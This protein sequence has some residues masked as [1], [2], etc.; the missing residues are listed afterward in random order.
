MK[1][2]LTSSTFYPE[3]AGLHPVAY[4]AAKDWMRRGHQVR[5]LTNTPGSF[6]GEDEIQIIRQ[7]RYRD[8]LNQYR[9]CDVVFQN[10][11]SIRYWLPGLLVQRPYVVSMG[12]YS[13]V[14]A[15]NHP[16]NTRLIVHM[17]QWIRTL[18]LRNATRNI[19][20]SAAVATGNRVPSRIIPPQFD[21]TQFKNIIPTSQRSSALLYVGRLVSDKGVDDLIRAVALVRKRGTDCRLVIVGA[22]PSRSSLESLAQEKGITDV[23]SFVGSKTPEEVSKLMNS[24]R[25]IVVPSKY[26]DPAPVIALEAIASGCDVIGTEGGGLA[27]NIGFCGLT[28]PNGDYI[29]L[30]G[31]IASVLAK[32]DQ[33]GEFADTK[34]R[35]LAR[36]HPERIGG[37]FLEE[38][39]NAYRLFHR[40]PDPE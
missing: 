6:P 7:P 28:Y 17:K 2:L 21:S 15:A 11:V 1:I 30:A 10:H 8:I 20:V 35:H 37:E 4:L 27:V 22:G 29:A 23:V 24:H 25:V 38:L 40:L 9:W 19:A 12:G 18:I 3:I 36:Y 16:A 13:S 39:E 5:L 26:N 14:R 33:L 32:G 31:R 34:D